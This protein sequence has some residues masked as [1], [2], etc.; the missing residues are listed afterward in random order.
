MLPGGMTDAQPSPLLK[1]ASLVTLLVVALALVFSLLPFKFA[2]AVSCGAPL[3][4][5]EAKDDRPIVG[6][7]RPTDACRQKGTSR[8]TV[9]AV[10][11]V[12]AV[13]AGIAPAFVAPPGADCRMGRH[14]DCRAWWAVGMGGMFGEALSCQCRCHQAERQGKFRN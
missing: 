11:A 6:F 4:G 8:L 9:V 5:S 3:L 7:A 14:D 1:L 12:L 10:V 2:R 13:G